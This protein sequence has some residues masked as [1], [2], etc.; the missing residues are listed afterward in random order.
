[1]TV[2]TMLHTRAGPASHERGQSWV[3][4]KD[5]LTKATL[6]TYDEVF[7]ATITYHADEPRSRSFVVNVRDKRTHID[8]IGVG[9]TEHEALLDALR[10]ILTDEEIAAATT[11]KAA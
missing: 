11:R 3:Q 9:A 8:G 4:S 2:I 1:M 6:H 5:A 10:K 7:A